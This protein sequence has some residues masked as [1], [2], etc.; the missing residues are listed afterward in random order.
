LIKIFKEYTKPSSLCLCNAAHFFSQCPPLG[1]FLPSSLA[2]GI[3]AKILCNSSYMTKTNEPPAPLIILDNAPLKKALFPSFLAIL[4]KQSS[5][6][7]YNYF[8]SPDYIINLLLT[9]S[10]G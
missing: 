2:T 5:V 4:T 1:F 10:N 6:P 7:L 9:V 8:F 3:G